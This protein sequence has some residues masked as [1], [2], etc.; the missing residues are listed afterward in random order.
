MPKV[1]F[2]KEKKTIE[3]PEGANLRKEAR[4]NGIE[5]YWGPHKYLHCRGFGVC[6]SCK[7]LIRK[8][9]EN[10]S[11]QGT[12]ERLNLL[13]PP[14][15]FSRIGHEHDLRLACQTEVH[16]DIEVET[17]PEMNWHGERFWA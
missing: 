15:V 7:V 17:Q 8:G 9:T 5:L 4:R 11:P 3:V 1:H 14:A 6:T 10:V 13:K 2:V 12:W 16:G